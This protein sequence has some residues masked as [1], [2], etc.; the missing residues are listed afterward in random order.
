[1][2]YIDAAK[3]KGVHTYVAFR[4]T[5]DDG[6]TTTTVAWANRAIATSTG[7][8]E[9]RILDVGPIERGMP[10]TSGGAL[11]SISTSLR[12]DNSDKGLD[13][14]LTG[15][16]TT[17]ELNEYADD[18]ILNL[19]GKVYD[20]VIDTDGTAYEDALTP[21]LYVSGS[22][23]YDGQTVIV[24]M[25]SKQDNLLGPSN[26]QLTIQDILKSSAGAHGDGTY[27]AQVA[28][29]SGAITQATFENVLSKWNTNLDA[30]AKFIYGA[31]VIPMIPVRRDSIEGTGIAIGTV[32]DAATFF[33]FVSKD[34]PYLA[35]FSSDFSEWR[36]AFSLTDMR[37][38]TPLSPK[39][40]KIERDV[41]DVDGTTRAIWVC[42]LQCQFRY[43]TGSD[44]EY[45][46]QQ[47]ALIPP[48]SVS[49]QL[50]IVG[51]GAARRDYGSPANVIKALVTDHAGSSVVESTS[52]TRLHKAIPHPGV[53]GGMYT[54]TT[55]L[56]E[57]LSHIFE[58]FAIDAWMGTDDKV[59]LLAAAGYSLDDVDTVNAGSIPKLGLADIFGDSWQEE[60][61]RGADRRGAPI[62]R[63][64]VDWTDEQRAFWQS[65][66]VDHVPGNVEIP[67]GQ[68]VESRVSG[69]WV[70]PRKASLA[71]SVGAGHRAY[72]AR[73]FTFETHIWVASY[74]LGQLFYITHPRG[75]DVTGTT[76]YSQR[77][78]RLERVSVDTGRRTCR[79]TFEDLGPSARLNPGILDD[80]GNWLLKSG[81]G[82]LT[83]TSAST[84]IATS[85]AFFVDPDHVGATVVTRGAANTSNQGPNR[86]IVSITDTTHAV[87]NYA[88][89]AT[90]TISASGSGI[91]A[92]W[93]LLYNHE[94]P[95]A[96][97]RDATYIQ[98]CEESTGLFTGG[99]S[100][101][102]Y[103]NG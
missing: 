58:A 101:F 46:D 11:E 55:P 33:L 87:V 37:L 100:G 24:P 26:L 7:P 29:T 68:R 34:E 47:L 95:P 74:E 96:G 84:T 92:K 5:T 23:V 59:R 48:S 75:L 80:Y 15:T 71:L 54:G 89:N 72:V 44:I 1:V 22:V 76:G 43:E 57:V 50:G 97:G 64:T 6:T 32:I 79:A 53:C 70:N 3:K 62:S 38:A 90:E 19:T 81:S 13:D 2:A 20:G 25:S 27:Y 12:L 85:A 77:L 98:V 21:T 94:L 83:L 14:L 102:T 66:L 18:S 51:T 17:N 82:D 9:A 31:P 42:Y 16:T 86:K 69:A 4:G 45:D 36:I 61:P 103:G 39:I 93:H 28:S 35:T 88:Y 73:R 10:E 8:I 41:T 67:L 63:I 99:D 30:A 52:F 91:D 60:I 65:Q 78:A 40:V 49:T 56:R